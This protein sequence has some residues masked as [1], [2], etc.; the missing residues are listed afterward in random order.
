MKTSLGT[1]KEEAYYKQWASSGYP[2]EHMVTATAQ[3]HDGIGAVPL[4]TGDEP[5][6]LPVLLQTLTRML[7]RNPGSLG[8]LPAKR[9][10]KP[11]HSRMGS[12]HITQRTGDAGGLHSR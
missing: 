8:T 9:L 5:K 6:L 3:I 2:S 11:R 1:V 12:Y 10:Q 7:C 4:L